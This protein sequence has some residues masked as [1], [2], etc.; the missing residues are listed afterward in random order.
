[1]GGTD[2]LV[3]PFP[4][5]HAYALFLIDARL[6]QNENVSAET[7]CDIFRIHDQGTGS[8]SM[9][10]EQPRDPEDMGLDKDDHDL[11][12]P[13]IQPDWADEDPNS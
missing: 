13:P 9:C 3:P 4:F 12:A 6:F 1:M 10:T 2:I 8:T 7:C 11:D 5:H